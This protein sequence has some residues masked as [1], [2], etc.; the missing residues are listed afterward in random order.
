MISRRLRASALVATAALLLSAC[1]AEPAPMQTPLPPLSASVQPS[2]SPSPTA[3]S[4]ADCVDGVGRI[5]GQDQEL[6][7]SGECDRIE[8]TGTRL[9][10][11]LSAARATQIVVHGDDNEVEAATVESLSIDGGSNDVEVRSVTTVS[12]RG[13]RNSVESDA[14]IGTAQIAGDDNEIDAPAL[15]DADVRGERNELPGP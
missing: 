4:P 9:D 5:D 6:T 7:L 8:I 14:P 1:S 15:A 3:E 13:D 12:V 11:D 10:V 2:L